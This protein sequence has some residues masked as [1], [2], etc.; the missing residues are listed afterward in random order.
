MFLTVGR[1]CDAIILQR[2]LLEAVDIRLLHR[3]GA[4]IYFDVDDAVM[5]HTKEQGV[6]E[7]QRANRRFAATAT[8]VDLVVAGSEHLAD[9]F[10]EKRAHAVVIPTTVDAA[11]YTVKH[12]APAESPR[13]VWIGSRSTLPYLQEFLP[14][15]AEAARRVPGLRLVTIADATVQDSP[16]PVEH[17]DWSLDTEARSLVQGDIGIAPTPANPWTEGKCGFKILQYMAAGLPVIASPVGANSDIV[18]DGQTGFLPQRPEDWPEIIESL[19][20]DVS[21]RQRLGRAGRSRVESHYTIHHAAEM[22]GRILAG[23][24]IPATDSRPFP[25]P[26]R[27]L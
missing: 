11:R 2:K 15:L 10:R 24:V 26:S 23:G 17:V 25:E 7:R 20:R 22:W 13:L 3:H 19:S 8:L 5:H 9:L 18:D 12:H 1:N 6:F 16:I 21:L 27:A 4:R 14:V